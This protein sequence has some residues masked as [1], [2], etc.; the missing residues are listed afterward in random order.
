MTFGFSRKLCF[1]E[2]CI[3]QF[4]CEAVLQTGNC[5]EQLQ[6]LHKFKPQTN[7]RA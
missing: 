1:L 5:R 2:F 7:E 3:A 6:H 4:C